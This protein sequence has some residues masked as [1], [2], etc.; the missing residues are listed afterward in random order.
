MG[1]ELDVRHYARC[2]NQRPPSARLAEDDEVAAV[3]EHEL[4]VASFAGASASTS[5]PRPATP[6]APPRPRPRRPRRGTPSL[7]ALDRRPGAASRRSL[8]HGRRRAPRTGPGSPGA[9][10]LASPGSTSST[11]RT[12]SRPAAARTWRTASPSRPRRSSAG[13]RRAPP[14]RPPGG[15]SSSARSAERGGGPGELD[16]PRRERQP[17]PLG[18]GAGAA[19]DDLGAPAAA[20][21]EARLEPQPADRPPALAPDARAG[22]RSSSSSARSSCWPE[23]ASGSS[24][25]LGELLASPARAKRLV[26]AARE[27][28]RPQ[29]GLA[30]AVGDRLGRQRGELAQRP[31][32]EPLEQSMHDASSASL[33]AASWSAS[34]S[35]AAERGVRAARRPAV[36]RAAAAPRPRR[37]AA[38]AGGRASASP[39]RGR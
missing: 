10:A 7:A 29:P 9:R 30:E 3:G 36:R 25:A 31:H 18:V 14:A 5:G 38:A 39:R 26:G 33:P 15:P 28:Q 4:E 2:S 19:Q 16:E 22:A 34:G 6:R 21:G 11:C 27:P 23:A 32:P 8:A 24:S 37:R 17:Q 12:A 20:A 13:E 35:P 1:V